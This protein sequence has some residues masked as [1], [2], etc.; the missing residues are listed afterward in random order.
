MA[1]GSTHLSTHT[2]LPS[3]HKDNVRDSPQL[4][5][6]FLGWDY[7]VYADTM[8]WIRTGQWERRG[9]KRS[10][11]PNDSF[12]RFSNH[13]CTRPIIHL[14]LGQGKFFV[15][16]R[17]ST[18]CLMLRL[19]EL[20]SSYYLDSHLTGNQ[21][22]TTDSFHMNHRRKSQLTGSLSE[23]TLIAHFKL[24]SFYATNLLFLVLR[25]TEIYKAPFL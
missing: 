20:L 25:Y 2:I 1:C 17:A 18:L 16:R 22:D 13:A 19:L 23:G 5:S 15:W 4:G 3:P 7:D 11:S 14:C 21:K 12:H 24:T 6:K 9:G 10:K 8:K